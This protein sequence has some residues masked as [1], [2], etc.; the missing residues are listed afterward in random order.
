M[1]LTSNAGLLR[2][3]VKH[4]QLSVISRF[5]RVHAAQALTRWFHREAELEAPLCTKVFPTLS[6][7]CGSVSR[8]PKSTWSAGRAPPLL[9]G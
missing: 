1:H 9:C 6:A 5:W 2:F 7:S 3:P 8:P 4:R